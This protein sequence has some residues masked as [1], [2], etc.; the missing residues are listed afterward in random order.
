MYFCGLPNENAEIAQMYLKW[1]KGFVNSK[2][3]SKQKRRGTTL[4]HQQE[5]NKRLDHGI[6]NNPSKNPGNIPSSNSESDSSSKLDLS[7]TLKKGVKSCTK[8]TLSNSISYKN[9]SPSYCV[10]ISQMSNISIPNN[11]KEALNDPQWKED[12]LE[13][14]RT[15]EKMLLGRRWI[16]QMV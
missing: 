14:M 10:F 11:M 1:Y 13:E 5:Y 2:E 3:Y 8:H 15:S 16:C 6:H 12:V 7:I 4:Q 9:I